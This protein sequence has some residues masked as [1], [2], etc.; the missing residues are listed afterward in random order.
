MFLVNG[1]SGKLSSWVFQ[2][3]AA[4]IKRRGSR[5]SIFSADLD[6]LDGLRLFIAH[7]SGF[8]IKS[9]KDAEWHPKMFVVEGPS[10]SRSGWK[11]NQ[12]LPIP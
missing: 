2:S 5:A 10:F 1:Y 3:G 8:W 4:L 12:F 9:G 7:L 11:Q 6:F